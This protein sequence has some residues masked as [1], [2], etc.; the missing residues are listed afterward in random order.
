MFKLTRYFAIIALVAVLI[1]SVTIGALFRYVAEKNIYALGEQQNAILG[2]A[3]ANAL[4]PNIKMFINSAETKASGF[5]RDFIFPLTDSILRPLI[6]ELPVVKVKIFNEVGVTLYSTNKAEFGERK[7]ED[8]PDLALAIKGAVVSELTLLD[9]FEGLSGPMENVY[10]MSSYLP[11]RDK[12]DDAIKAVIETYTDVTAQIEAI[13]STQNRLFA[14]AFGVLFIVYLVLLWFIRIADVVIQQRAKER[15]AH[16]QQIETINASIDQ[17][18]REATRDLVVARDEAVRANEVKSSF[19]ANMSHELRTPLNAIIGYSELILDDREAIKNEGSRSDIGK[20]N[21]AGRNLLLLIND[22]L[23]L[24]KIEAGKLELNPVPVDIDQFAMELADLVMPLVDARQNSFE[25]RRDPLVTTVVADRLRLRQ[26]LLNLIG[27]AAKFT[28]RGSIRLEFRRDT[29][30]ARR[31]VE[32][33]VAD[34]GIGMSPAE[35]AKIFEAF[36]QAIVSISERYGGTGLGLTI[37]R[38]LCL[39]MG[40]DVTVT[41]QPGVGTV[42]KVYLPAGE[43]LHAEVAEPERTSTT[44]RASVSPSSA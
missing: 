9:K 24:S 27:N 18:L 38:K 29:A 1:A 12:G 5:D 13:Q 33:T 36:T 44:G 14:Y 23:D 30:D 43:N 4:W 34:T 15:E 8:Y 19:L 42:F 7:T 35:L 32:I 40:G 2:K 22:I 39:L 3:I 10:V 11:L 25:I 6:A 20:I 17:S 26:I 41:S 31:R 21:K 16:T 28:E 37:T